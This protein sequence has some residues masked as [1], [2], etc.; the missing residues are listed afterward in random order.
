LEEARKAI[1]SHRFSV[2]HKILS[3]WIKKFGLTKILRYLDYVSKLK[4]KPRNFEAYMEKMLKSN[5]LELED[6]KSKWIELNRITLKALM[7]SYPTVPMEVYADYCAIPH[8]SKEWELNFN[9]EAFATN[10]GYVFEYEANN[11]TQESVDDHD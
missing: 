6:K 2:K 9:P 3:T 1:E 5:T 8:K 11:L 4:E 7:E 10:M